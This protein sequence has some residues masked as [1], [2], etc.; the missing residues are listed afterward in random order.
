MLLRISRSVFFSLFH[1]VA[2][3]IGKIPPKLSVLQDR[4]SQFPQT[5]L[6][7]TDALIPSLSLSSF[8]GLALVYPSLSCPGDF[9]IGHSTAGVPPCR[10]AVITSG[11]AL[12]ELTM[13]TL[14]QT[15]IL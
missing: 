3:Y 4:Q 5:L 9:R 7:I 1:Q 14:M 8:T 13:L 2:I 12:E 11:K 10:E 6:V 15:K